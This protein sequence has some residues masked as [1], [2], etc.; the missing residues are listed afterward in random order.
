MSTLEF[1][2]AVITGMGLAA[3]AVSLW[4]LRR[5]KREADPHLHRRIRHGT[6]V[7]SIDTFIILQVH[8]ELYPD[9][10][11]R[12]WSNVTF[13]G[14]VFVTAVGVFLLMVIGSDVHR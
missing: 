9:S 6:L 1:A 11:L 10:R 3:T 8:R 7:T 12:L 5:V 2:G 13:V 14:G 4:L